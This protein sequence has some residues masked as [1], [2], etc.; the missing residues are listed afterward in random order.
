[1]SWSW[2][3]PWAAATG[4]VVLAAACGGSAS[5]VADKAGGETVVSGSPRSMATST[6]TGCLRAAS[7]RRKPSAVSGDR[8][9]RG[10]DDLGDGAR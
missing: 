3:R 6:T 2:S 8:L 5:G 7:V 1:M 4:A 10:D 9:G